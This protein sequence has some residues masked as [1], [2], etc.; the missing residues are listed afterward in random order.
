MFHML[1]AIA[2]LELLR[3]SCLGCAGAFQPG[4]YP[5]NVLAVEDE[6]VTFGSVG[7]C[8]WGGATRRVWKRAAEH[9]E[10]GGLR[11][12]VQDIRELYTIIVEAKDDLGFLEHLGATAE[13]FADHKD[14]VVGL[15]RSA[16]G[17]DGPVP[18]RDYDSLI[19]WDRVSRAL[20]AFAVMPRE[21]T[22][23]KHCARVEVYGERP[24]TVEA[25]GA[26]PGGLPWRVSRGGASWFVVN[27]IVPQALS[28]LFEPESPARRLVDSRQY[29][30]VEVWDDIRAL[31]VVVQEVE[32]LDGVGEMR[33][34]DAVSPLL[35]DFELLGA[36][37]GRTSLKLVLCPRRSLII[38]KVVWQ[39]STWP[40][41][42]IVSGLQLRRRFDTIESVLKKI[43]LVSDWRQSPGNR[44]IVIHLDER[45]DVHHV[46]M[47]FARAAWSD[48][49]FRGEPTALVGLVRD[50]WGAMLAVGADQPGSAIL[51]RSVGRRAGHWLDEYRLLADPHERAKD[52][53]G[54]RVRSYGIYVSERP[55]SVDVRQVAF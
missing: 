22:T 1:S 10:L 51:L 47:D 8:E 48:A 39:L 41:G 42:P 53:T 40:G 27:P 30:T 25:Y 14:E 46:D 29:W 54:K 50:G 7:P 23:E 9:Y 19:T 43:V 26:Q 45:T 38:D 3:L 18:E 33:R 6:L 20:S 28:K 34:V 5:P 31:A 55:A 17:D 16:L 12:P 24:L 2:L 35:N 32:E 44:E 37:R 36:A 21:S 52:T 15:V 11:V 49:G 4:V 13:Q